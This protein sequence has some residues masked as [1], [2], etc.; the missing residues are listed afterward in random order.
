[1]MRWLIDT[2]LMIVIDEDYYFSFR[3]FRVF[4]INIATKYLI[5]AL[6]SV[7]FPKIK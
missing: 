4:N 2:Y 1:M 5:Y 6:L 3:L 7:R